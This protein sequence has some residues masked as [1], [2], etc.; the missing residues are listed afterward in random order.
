MHTYDR[1]GW[2]SGAEFPERDAGVAPANTSTT[3]TPGQWR[4]NWN[5]FEWLDTVYVAPPAPG[6]DIRTPPPVLIRQAHTAMILLGLDDDV[7]AAIDAI[8]DPIER[9]IARVDWTQSAVVE[10]DN[11]FVQ[12]LAPALGFT[13]AQLADIFAWSRTL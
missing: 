13:R 4:A 11:P 1:H 2:Y 10:F 7:S 12:S 5:G 6:A 8:E 3:T 9:K